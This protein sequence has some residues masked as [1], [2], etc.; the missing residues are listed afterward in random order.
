MD[1]VPS[2]HDQLSTLAHGFKALDKSEQ[3]TLSNGS[4]PSSYTQLVDF[5]NLQHDS[6]FSLRDTIVRFQEQVSQVIH[7]WGTRVSRFRCS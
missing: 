4:T 3:G 2:L 6:H 1:S 7:A 5:D